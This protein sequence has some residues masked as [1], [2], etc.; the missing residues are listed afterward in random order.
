MDVERSFGVCRTFAQGYGPRIWLHERAFFG[1][2][3]LQMKLKQL[4]SWGNYDKSIRDEDGERLLSFEFSAYDGGKDLNNAIA[5][6]C[7][8]HLTEVS[9][10]E[11]QVLF[12]I[13]R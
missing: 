10:G 6:L 4:S 1:G 3:A 7:D 9:L 8:V 11:L 13:H 12:P 5:C 2:T